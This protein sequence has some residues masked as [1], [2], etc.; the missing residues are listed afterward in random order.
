MNRFYMICFDVADQRRLRKVA[1]ELENFGQRVQRSIFECWLDD[2]DLFELKQRLANC[3]QAGDDSI[4]YYSLC[5]QDIGDIQI[6]GSG[7]V[8]PDMEYLCF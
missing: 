1:N 2:S 7:S 5:T 3:I 6:D 4:R 8:S